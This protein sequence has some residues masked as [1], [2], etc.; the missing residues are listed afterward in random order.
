[1]KVV[2]NLIFNSLACGQGV[3]LPGIGSLKVELQPAKL[4][5][6]N[7]LE[8]AVKRVLYSKSEPEELISIVDI[9]ERESGQDR[10]KSEATYSKWAEQE[11]SERCITIQGVGTIKNDF[12]TPSEEFKKI[13]NPDQRGFIKLRRRVK[14]GRIAA[15]TLPLMLAVG[16]LFYYLYAVERAFDYG[17]NWSWDNFLNRE[18]ATCTDGVVEPRSTPT[19]PPTPAEMASIIAADTITIG[20][21]DSLIVA[22]VDPVSEPTAVDSSATKYHVIAGAYSTIEN[23]NKY[24]AKARLSADTLPYK[25]VPIANGRFL[26]SIYESDQEELASKRCKEFKDIDPSI[27]MYSESADE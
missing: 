21:P 9:I 5:G 11:Q 3:I 2:D 22:E 23:A 14:S 1:M 10:A 16:G 18:A 7:R 13:L 8:I 6:N 19:Q 15:I 25:I 27:W 24:I 4:K 17:Y 26:I 12:F 20:T